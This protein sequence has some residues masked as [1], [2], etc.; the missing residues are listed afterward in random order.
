MLGLCMDHLYSWNVC[1]VG[2]I[3]IG[4]GPT[5][6]MEFINLAFL[7]FLSN[8]FKIENKSIAS[9]HLTNEAN[10]TDARNDHRSNASGNRVT[11][12]VESIMKC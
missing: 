3:T 2:K 5:F 6:F 11:V 4:N 12:S 9:D 1:I 7:L 10:I 8:I